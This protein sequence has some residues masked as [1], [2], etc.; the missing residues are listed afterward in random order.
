MGSRSRYNK[1]MRM[2]RTKNNDDRYPSIVLNLD[3]YNEL[4]KL[5]ATQS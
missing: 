5:I 4:N 1:G 2:L 3:Q